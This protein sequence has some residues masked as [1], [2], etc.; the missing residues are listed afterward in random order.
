M[1]L[2]EAVMLCVLPLMWG[3]ARPRV[4]GALMAGHLVSWV[5]PFAPAFIL[6][7]LLTAAVV[8]SRPAGEAQ[9]LI[10]LL[11]VGMALTGIGYF[12]ATD[13]MGSVGQPRAYADIL[14]L[15]GWLQLI[16]LGVWGFD[17]TIGHRFR[18]RDAVVLPH[19][20]AERDFS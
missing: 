7:D 10:G 11:S 18:A 2:W 16:I 4:W 1:S 3:G 17:G 5:L 13:I 9:K 15:L 12:I 6:I 14:R 20:P 8:L 19:A